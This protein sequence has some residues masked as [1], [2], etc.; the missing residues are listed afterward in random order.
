MVFY[1]FFFQSKR[2]KTIK[3]ETDDDDAV[4]FMFYWTP[5]RGL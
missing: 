4:E 2:S 1:Q 3:E 5:G